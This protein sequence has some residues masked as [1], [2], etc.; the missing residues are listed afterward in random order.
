MS[1]WCS[2]DTIGFDDSEPPS[3]QVRSYATGWSNHY[4]TTTGDVEQEA[5]VEIAHIAPWCVPGHRDIG[6]EWDGTG[7]VYG[8]WL[9]LDIY[10]QQHDFHS[11]GKPTGAPLS[12]SVVMDETA[13]RELRDQLTSWLDAKKVRPR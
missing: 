1:I 11:G 9:R 12:A 7:F 5:S 4:P 2:H 10:S 6:D 13:V 3:G 8:D